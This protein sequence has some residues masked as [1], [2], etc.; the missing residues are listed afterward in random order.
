MSKKSKIGAALSPK[1]K[2]S[3]KHG[4]P[5][6][7]MVYVGINRSEPIE[8]KEICY[9]A[10]SCEKKV[11]GDVYELKNTSNEGE[12]R[13]IQV[14]GVH[15]TAAIH[16]ICKQF[17]I[18]ALVEED[19]LNTNQR[20]KVEEFD[21]YVFLSVKH[22]NYNAKTDAIDVEQVSLVLSNNFLISFQETTTPIFAQ[23]AERLDKALGGVRSKNI[24]FL[25]YKIL[26]TIIDDYFI[27]LDYLSDQSD[28]IEMEVTDNP[29]QKTSHEI[30]ILKKKIVT[31]S[32][33]ILPTRELLNRVISGNMQ[34]ISTESMNYF[35]D[36]YDHAYLIS[37]N[38][39]NKKMLMAD[40]MNIY[41]SNI[42]NKLNYIMKV[43]TIISTI[44]MPLSFLTGVYGM[45]LKVL[46]GS[47]NPNSIYYFFGTCMLIVFVMLIYFK[48]KR[49]F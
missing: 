7:S 33:Y 10:D 34:F 1:R 25:L 13:W 21:E 16:N 24:D 8:I 6:E 15:D 42:S 18:H 11:M 23:I 12:K 39:D 47:E 22:L 31:V 5:P 26:D 38:I 29:N 14:L 20:T 46:P 37:E 44:F 36:V 28:E 40:L 35:K 4:L 30:Q 48:N 2:Y 32:K 49:W 3:S 41:L 9:S 17:G 19:I 27:I 43:L 45:N